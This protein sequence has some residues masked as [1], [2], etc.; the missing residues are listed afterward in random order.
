MYGV[1][2]GVSGTHISW[3]WV[4]AVPPSQGPNP[5]RLWCSALVKSPCPACTTSK[6]AICLHTGSVRSLVSQGDVCFC[7]ASKPTHKLNSR[8]F[9]CSNTLTGHKPTHKLNAHHFFCN[10]LTGY[11]PTH[12]LNSRRFVCNSKFDWLHQGACRAYVQWLLSQG[13]V[14]EEQ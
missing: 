7:Q 12:K 2:Q 5:A 6:I 9:V 13:D 14:W 4:T 1:V 11:K 8:H 10:T 3:C